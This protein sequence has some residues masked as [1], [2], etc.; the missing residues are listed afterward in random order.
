MFQLSLGLYGPCGQREATVQRQSR[1]P[2][3]PLR[4]DWRDPE[5]YR[6]LLAL[7]KAGWAAEWLRRSPDFA[8]IL[9]SFA[10]K[11]RT[12]QRPVGGPRI[13]I[14]S[15]LPVDARWGVIF[16]RCHRTGHH[17]L[18]SVAGTC[19]PHRRR[20]PRRTR[21]RGRFRCAAAPAACRGSEDRRRG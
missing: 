1:C 8:D 2:E 16:C 4:P 20:V 7:D 19:R 21:R 18:V 15:D 10:E 14:L 13:I 17:L 6:P 9:N 3:F 5:H 12:T 11:V